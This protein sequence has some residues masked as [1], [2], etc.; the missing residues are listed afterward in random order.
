M[1][2][3]QENYLTKSRYIDGLRCPKKIWYGVHEHLPKKDPEP[4]S[5]LD[6]GMRV[7]KGAHQLFPGGVEI[8]EEPWEHAK[9]VAKTNVLIAASEAAAIFEAAFEY[10]NIRIR[11]DVLERLAN[12]GWGIREVKSSTSVKEEKFH[13]DDVAVQLYVVRGSGLDVTSVELIHVNSEFTKGEGEGSRR[14]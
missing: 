5:V 1:T 8:M 12:G 11:V 13:I 4:F 7:G 14:C 9:A 3:P 2:V 6:V 10:E